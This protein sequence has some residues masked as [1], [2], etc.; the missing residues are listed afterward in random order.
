MM[1]LLTLT[2]AVSQDR[3]KGSGMFEIGLVGTKDLE[4]R[5]LSYCIEVFQNILVVGDNFMGPYIEDSGISI[6]YGI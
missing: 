4:K 5:S 1:N 3:E 6:G 2:Y